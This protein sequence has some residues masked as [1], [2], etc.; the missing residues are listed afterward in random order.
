MPNYLEERLHPAALGMMIFV[1]V[2]IFMTVVYQIFLLGSEHWHIGFLTELPKDAGRS[3][4]IY[5]VIISSGLI[6]ICCMATALPIGLGCSIYIYLNH[7]YQFNSN[8]W[9]LLCSDVLA[10]IPSIIYG[11][12]GASLFCDFFKLG[13]SI[14][15][16]G[17]TLACMVLPLFIRLCHQILRDIPDAWIQASHTTCLSQ[18]RFLFQIIFPKYFPQFSGAFILCLGRSLAETAALLFTSGYVLR[19]PESIFDSGRSLSVHIY[20]LSMNLPGG[21]QPAAASALFLLAFL[22]I[23]TSSAQIL[24]KKWTQH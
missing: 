22:M 4:G 15:S 9:F 17:L 20:E 12:L 10:S 5:P 7:L 14:L 18:W 16:G 2:A 21:D 13:Y 19:T 6:L 24:S 1:V 11:L 23:S 3:G 8:S